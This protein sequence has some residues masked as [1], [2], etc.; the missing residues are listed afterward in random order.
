MFQNETANFSQSLEN[1]GFAG[2]VDNV[3]IVDGTNV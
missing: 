1:T 2:I 3:E